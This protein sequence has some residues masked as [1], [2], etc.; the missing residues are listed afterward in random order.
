MRDHPAIDQ[1]AIAALQELSTAGSDDFL[2]EIITLY[3][4]DTPLL[5]AQLKQALAAGDGV[6]VSRL[7]H[8]IKGSSGNFGANHLAQLAHEL[9]LAAPLGGATV[10][11]VK[12]LQ[13]EYGRVAAALTASIASH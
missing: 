8:S 12:A 6:T 1:R 4:Q 2:C 13:A 11:N 9:E 10:A 3:L 7:A 5:L